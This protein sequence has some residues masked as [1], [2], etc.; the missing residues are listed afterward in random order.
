MTHGTKVVDFGR[1][2]GRDDRNKVG[3]I[4]QIAVVQVHFD[5]RLVSVSVN[6][7]NS[8]RVEGRRSTDNSMDLYRIYIYI[9]I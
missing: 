5:S 8:S 2:D 4:T 7:I 6:V 3:S 9:Y 1:F